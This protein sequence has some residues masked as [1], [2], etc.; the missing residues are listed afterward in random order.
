MR[1]ERSLTPPRAGFLERFSYA[2]KQAR[3]LFQGYGGQLGAA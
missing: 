3:V 2:I 1:R